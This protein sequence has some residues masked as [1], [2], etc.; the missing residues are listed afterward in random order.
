MAFRI[1]A[2]IRSKAS[3]VRESSWSEG[4]IPSLVIDRDTSSSHRVS[5]SCQV[6]QL[7]GRS[8]GS[9]TGG[10]KTHGVRSSFE[11][12]F[13][14]K[15][16]RYAAKASRRFLR[17]ASSEGKMESTPKGQLTGCRS[18]ERSLLLQSMAPSF[19]C[20]ALTKQV[21]DFLF[22]PLHPFSLGVCTGPHVGLHHFG[23]G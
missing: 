8:F 4:S 5:R 19:E 17:S 18:E 1:R 13:G 20:F 23:S 11:F 10:R 21:F 15:V 3:R 9:G 14:A 2:S 7:F 16:A 22:G 12:D 6:L